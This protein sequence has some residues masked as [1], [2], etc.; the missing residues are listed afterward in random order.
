ML[1]DRFRR[2]AIARRLGDRV[3]LEAKRHNRRFEW[4]QG[5]HLS[6][7]LAW[8]TVRA[9]GPDGKVFTPVACLHFVSS[10][11]PEVFYADHYLEIDDKNASADMASIWAVNL[12]SSSFNDASCVSSVPLQTAS[13]R[14]IAR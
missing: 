12:L 6:C 5:D 8:K 10:R 3:V 1:S 14:M 9:A 2:L 7:Y 11:N 4:H 13:V